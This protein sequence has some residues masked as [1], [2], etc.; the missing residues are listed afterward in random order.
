MSFIAKIS[1]L[2]QRVF[3]TYHCLRRSSDPSL[4]LSRSPLI[5]CSM[6]YKSILICSP[7][8]KEASTLSFFRYYRTRLIAV[9]SSTIVKSSRQQLSES[10]NFPLSTWLTTFRIPTLAT[11]FFHQTVILG[12]VPS[13]KT[14]TF[15]PLAASSKTILLSNTSPL[16]GD[17]LVCNLIS[18]SL[19]CSSSSLLRYRHTSVLRHHRQTSETRQ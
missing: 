2:Y 3:S 9:L 14:G 11:P 19:S 17:H 1:P 12:T 5:P 15:F 18:I 10:P 16:S 4:V 13:Y 7:V 6:H 8:S